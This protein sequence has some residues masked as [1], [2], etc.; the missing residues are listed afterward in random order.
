MNK[1]KAVRIIQDYELIPG[2]QSRNIL[3]AIILNTDYD[4]KF[5]QILSNKDFDKLKQCY[6]QYIKDSN[7][8]QPTKFT[9]FYHIIK[10]KYPSV[11]WDIEQ[12]RC[13]NVL[14]EILA[15][16]VKNLRVSFEI[17]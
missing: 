11:S 17:E 10:Q 2:K 5:S 7:D 3:K 15:P 13:N 8:N 14:V 1:N 16:R 12:R 9:P 6:Q 4:N